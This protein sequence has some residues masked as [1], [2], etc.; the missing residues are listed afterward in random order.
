[1]PPSPLENLE[2]GPTIVVVPWDDPVVDTAGFDVR[3]E[4]VELFWLN[5]LGPTTTWLLRR[6]VH[7]LERHPLGYELDL[8]E[9]ARA[10]GLA[11]TRGAT[12]PFGR[13]LQRCVLFGVA[14]E[15]GGGLAVRRRVPP[16]SARQLGRMP[17]TLRSAHEG[18]MR[19][20]DTTAVDRRAGL[21]AQAMHEAGDEPDRIERQL[22]ALGVEP[23]LALVHSASA[24]PPRAR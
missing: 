13:A 1:M 11:Y 7:G 4:Y 15:L 23:R 8:W 21:L 2:P 24:N 3:S 14:H 16:V 20:V 6:L 9:T 17:E 5:V 19:P 22:L 12:S 10:L 18:W